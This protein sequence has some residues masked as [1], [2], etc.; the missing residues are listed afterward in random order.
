M[1]KYVLCFILVFS[2]S[3]IAFSQNVNQLLADFSKTNEV[4]KVKIGGFLMS[5][6]KLL[7]GVSNNQIV[8]GV[9][10]MEVMTLTNPSE[11]IRRNFT[12]AF[13]KVKDSDGYETLIMINEKESNVRIMAKKDKNVIREII[14]LCSGNDEPAIIKFSGKI[15]ESDLAQLSKL[16]K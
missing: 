5:L 3:Q 10:S 2:V 14:F 11:Q 16:N 13:S 4:E 9:K 1:K 8:K 7:G 12:D 6:S 15:K